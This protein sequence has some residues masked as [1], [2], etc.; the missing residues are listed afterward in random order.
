MCSLMP[1]LQVPSS[2]GLIAASIRFQIPDVCPLACHFSS[3]GQCTI[4]ISQVDVCLWSQQWVKVGRN[5]LLFELGCLLGKYH[6]SQALLCIALLC[7][8]LGKTGHHSLYS[9]CFFCDNLTQNPWQ[10][11]FVNLANGLTQCQLQCVLTHL[12]RRSFVFI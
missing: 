11:F 10:L 8:S 3:P 5:Q 9:K 1:S 7:N 6:W 4:W 12:S 2:Q